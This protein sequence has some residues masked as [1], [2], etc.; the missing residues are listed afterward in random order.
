MVVGNWLFGVLWWFGLLSAYDFCLW[1]V[2]SLVFVWFLILQFVVCLLA[3]CGLFLFASFT[4]RF[5][6]FADYGVVVLVDVVVLLF[7]VFCYLLK[8][9]VCFALFVC[10]CF[11]HL[12]VFVW[13]VC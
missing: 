5:D 2:T 8:L 6:L 13:F 9:F 11:V 7:P 4:I 10:V 1:F 12:L 3:L